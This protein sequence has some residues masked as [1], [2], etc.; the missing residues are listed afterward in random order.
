M[1]VLLAGGAIAAA[2]LSADRESDARR[3]ALG[4]SLATFLIALLVFVRF[5]AAAEGYQFVDSFEWIRAA[6]AGFSIQ[7]AV[8]VDGLSAPLVLLLGLLT[9]VA[10]L[11]SW[12]ID[13]KPRQYF[14]W[15]LFLETAI[16]GVFLSLDLVQFFLFWELELLPMYMLISQWGTGR[17]IYSAT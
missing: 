4:F 13:V 7:Y 1:P 14:A 3:V 6:E 16:A 10:V 17:R 15:L 5:D 9:V 11:V 8:G 2:L 12:N